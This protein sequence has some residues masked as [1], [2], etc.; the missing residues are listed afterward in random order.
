[1][2]FSK[3]PISPTLLTTHTLFAFKAIVREFQSTTILRDCSLQ[4][5]VCPT[6]DFGLDLKSHSYLCSR[7]TR[8]MRYD[9]VRD[10]ACIAD[11]AS[12]V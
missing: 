1:M 12:R 8:E 7:D 10:L 6:W 11:Y 4:I 3:V 9:L 5:L 2:A